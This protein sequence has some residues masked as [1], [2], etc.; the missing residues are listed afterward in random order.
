MEVYLVVYE[1]PGVLTFDKGSHGDSASSPAATWSSGATATTS[2]ANEIFF[3]AATSTLE[4]PTVTGAGTWTT[5]STGAG[6]YDQAAGYQIVSSTQ[7]ATFSGTFSASGRAY[8]AVVATFYV[9]GT[10][11]ALAGAGSAASG[12]VI[13]VTA[14]L[15]GAGSARA[16]AAIGATAPLA[17]A[18]AATATPRISVTA[19]L[20]GAGSAS[21][22][23]AGFIPAAAAPAGAG[24]ATATAGIR[25]TAALAGTG[26][27]SA[28]TSGLAEDAS[29]PP[30]AQTAGGAGN[31]FIESATF[32]PPAGALLVALC[33]VNY[34]AYPGSPPVLSV[35]DTDGGT[36]TPGTQIGNAAA[37]TVSNIFT[38]PCPVS[39]GPITVTLTRGSDTSAALVE[40]AVRVLTGANLSQAGA[41]QGSAAGSSAA[42][43]DT[44]TTR[45]KGSLVY[46][47]GTGAGTGQS[48]AALANTTQVD[49]RYDTVDTGLLL[50]GRA[51]GT[52]VTPGAGS[53]GAVG[54]TLGN[55]AAWAVTGLEIL[56]ASG[57]SGAAALAGTG[58]AA[59]GAII[60]VTASLAGAGSA[61]LRPPETSPS[62]EL[63]GFGSFGSVPSGSTVNSVTVAVTEFQSAAGQP[64]ATYELWDYSGA[65]AQIGTTQAGTAGTSTSNVSTATFTGATY[66]MLPTLRVRVYGRGEPGT[67]YTESVDGVS[68]VVNYTATGAIAVTAA[69]A[70]AGRVIVPG[71]AVPGSIL[72]EAASVILDEAGQPVTDEGA[73]LSGAAIGGTGSASSGVAIRVTAAL[74]GTGS[75]TAAPAAIGVTAALAGAGGAAAVPAAIGVTATPAGVGGAYAGAVTIGITAAI[76]GTGHA[77]PV[78]VIAV[79]AALAGT[80]SAAASPAVTVT[81]SL[82]GAGG[83]RATVTVNATITPA[84]PARGTGSAGA[85]PTVRVT[86]VLAGAGGA[87]VSLAR[88]PLFLTARLAG[89]GSAFEHFYSID[90][91]VYAGIAVGVLS[92]GTSRGD[93]WAVRATRP[94]GWGAAASKGD[95][96]AASGA[97]SD[98]GIAAATKNDGTAAGASQG[99]LTAGPSVAQR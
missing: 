43:A 2:Q 3:G 88:P 30:T 17:G 78:A 31:L 25:V 22:A 77:T 98:G 89:A 65:P 26:S 4:V 79:T 29:T 59:S 11:G 67:G 15:A 70:G 1:V 35:S 38:R 60:G 52:T 62:L 39:P 47:C 41:A 10:T 40:L 74:G 92:A 44:V 51:S 33:V 63:Y 37:L 54:F 7:A 91:S 42:F 12:A 23:R 99:V 21:A 64:A 96:L 57:D 34:G 93:G 49:N 32:T 53:P 94:D 55:S 18:G 86:A 46:I 75:A 83:A 81:A 14:A 97:S 56:P 82:A 45:V 73:G 84:A 50:F 36:W 8:G 90:I 61:A 27:A 16:T 5:Q 48:A 58:Q 13:G 87:S 19:A 80:G 9:A 28:G 71:P 20:A 66:G 85:V 72:D 76:G 68:L 6:T 69:L 95:G 24:S